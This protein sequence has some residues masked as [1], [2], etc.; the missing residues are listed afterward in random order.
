ML[1]DFAVFETE[2]IE[3][4]I[5]FSG[6]IGLGIRH[7]IIALRKYVEHKIVV[8]VIVVQIVQVC[9]APL[10]DALVMLD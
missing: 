4:R 5:L 2:N 1:H 7:H 8:D 10:P 6:N 9:A 3:E